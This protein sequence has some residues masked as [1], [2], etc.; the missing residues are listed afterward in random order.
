MSKLKTKRSK[1]IHNV[2]VLTVSFLIFR[3]SAHITIAHIFKEGVTA[4]YLPVAFGIFLIYR[5]GP[6][7]LIP[8]FINGIIDGW[9]WGVQETLAWPGVALTETTSV[10]LSWWLYI[11]ILK[12]NPAIPNLNNLLKL[13]VF[14][15]SIPVLYLIAVGRTIILI[16]QEPNLINY[17]SDIFQNFYGD[18]AGISA[19]TV[20]LLYYFSDFQLRPLNKINI[21]FIKRAMFVII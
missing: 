10:Y 4:I 21:N 8:M 14:G 1:Y 12:G 7:I 19:Y 17:I 13:L 20:F 5:Y 16:I 3:I 9:E 11:K 2:I 15:I 18:F 6:K